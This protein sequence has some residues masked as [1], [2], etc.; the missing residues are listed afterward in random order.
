MDICLTWA[1]YFEKDDGSW[2][3]KPRGQSIHNIQ[4]DNNQRFYLDGKEYLNA[5]EEKEVTLRIDIVDREQE[6]IITVTFLNEILIPEGKS[7][8]YVASEFLIFQPQIRVIFHDNVELIPL[9]MS[10]SYMPS[11]GDVITDNEISYYLHRDDEMYGEGL[12]CSITWRRLDPSRSWDGSDVIPNIPPFI[13]TDG[14][15]FDKDIREKFVLPDLK[16]EYTPIYNVPLADF[17]WT[18]STHI[19]IFSSTELSDMYD[20]ND[21]DTAL[22]PLILAY[23]NWFSQLR[24]SHGEGND[25]ERHLIRNIESA[26]NRIRSSITIL[27]ENDDAR[28]AFCFAQKVMSVQYLWSKPGQDLVWRPF[29]LAFILLTLESLVNTE[30]R[31][32]DICDLLW[33]PTGGGKTEAYLCIAAFIMAYRRRRS[34][35]HGDLVRLNYAGTTV[36]SRY[37]LRLLS[38]QQFRRTL[39]MITAAD[40]LRTVRDVSNHIGW[41]PNV[42]STFGDYPFGRIQFSIGLWVGGGITPNHLHDGGWGRNRRP[43]A[44][45]RLLRPDIRE[46]GDPAQVIQ[47]PACDNL[48]IIPDQGLPRSQREPWVISYVLR[49]K[50]PISSSRYKDNEKPPYITKLE[51]PTLIDD[52]ENKHYSLRVEITNTKLLSITAVNRELIPFILSHS[53]IILKRKLTIESANPLRPGYFI[54]RRKSSRSDSPIQYDFKILCTNPKCILGKDVRW[55]SG[56]QVNSLNPSSISDIIVPEI[57]NGPFSIGDGQETFMSRV[58]IPAYTVDD[59]IYSKCPTMIISTVDKFARLPFDPKTSSIFGNINCYNPNDEFYR[60]FHCTRKPTSGPFIPPELIIQD[61]L[62]LINGPLGSMVGLYETVVDTLIREGGIN[63]KYIS[64]TATIKNADAQIKS[65]FDKGCLQFPPSSPDRRDD[66]FVREKIS[67]PVKDQEPGRLYMGVCS[68]GL[69]PLTPM[70]R[71][72]S[73]LFNTGNIAIERYSDDDIEKFWTVV[74]YFNAIK[75]LA[76]MN[77]LYRHDIPEQLRNLG[78]TRRIDDAPPLE[79]CGRISSQELPMLLDTITSN[80]YPSETAPDALLTTSM[81][82][83]GIDIPH[84]SAMVVTGQPKTTSSYIQST[85]RVGRER[86]GLVIT[87]YKAS[88]PRDLSHYERFLG[89]HMKLDVHVEPVTVNPFS[90]SLIERFG[91]PVL[92]SILRNSRN[93]NGSWSQNNNIQGKI[94]LSRPSVDDDINYALSQVTSRA[95]SQP[96]EIRQSKELVENYLES[97]IDRWD[98]IARYVDIRDPQLQLKWVEYVDANSHV[99]LGDELHERRGLR[100]VYRN[101][102]YSLRNVEQTTGF[103]V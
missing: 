91:G 30:S 45:T 87:F 82:G 101:V 99:V 62:H 23:E 93:V 67:H 39:R 47:C 34:I 89:Y 70:V 40:Y 80:K 4:F 61:E 6:K 76:G 103:E 73:I 68:P 54:K 28:L 56:Y 92:V 65:L 17:T 16:S 94:I 9:K 102:P 1:R 20:P 18:D 46:G 88:R 98:Q 52:K 41:R 49:D 44:L 36:I 59:Q 78:S 37:T 55:I 85:G 51:G 95:L 31:D 53:R 69:G 79:L 64:S 57:N 21:I 100:S 15:L 81:F 8:E 32:R 38:I 84:L 10:D 48:L 25:I 63:P 35:C 26:I 66:F 5:D 72:W 7:L 14:A 77:A 96:T 19:P 24:I 74:G 83:T 29:Q 42:A 13:W 86:G 27:K 58:P 50:G 97:H 2:E 11:S 12:L 43:G 71:I 75:E 90:I 60:R 33:I 22:M 3:R